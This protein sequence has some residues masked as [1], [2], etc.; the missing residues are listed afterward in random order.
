MKKVV[1]LLAIA[2]TVGF[3][4]ANAQ[5]QA[6]KL[7]Y[8]N[9]QELLTLMPEAA[10]ADTT[11]DRYTR[12]LEDQYKTMAQE[13]QTKLQEYQSNKDTW[14]PAIRETKER[15]LSDLQS[16]M[17]EFQMNAQDSIQMKKAQLFKPLLDKAQKAIHDVGVEGN[18]DYIFDGS[19]LLYAK[20]A[21]NLLPKVKA[22]LGIK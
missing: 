20:D 19:G 4:Q 7:G 9:S 17:Q 2:L 12:A 22:K 10:Q 16:R 21:Q 1:F 14:T 11:L 3:M 6:P 13:G 15:A 5:T 8:I 18:Y